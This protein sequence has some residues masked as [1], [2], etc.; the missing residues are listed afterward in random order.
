MEKANKAEVINKENYMEEKKSLTQ[1]K[2]KSFIN[3]DYFAQADFS[4]LKMTLEEMLKAGVHFGHKKSRRHPKMN[5]Y[6]FAT[7]NGISIFD[8]EKTLIKLQSALDFIKEIKRA[9]RQILFV[10]TKKQARYLIKSAAQRCQMPFVNERW[11]GGTFTNFKMIR[12]RVDYLL[13][14]EDKQEKG[15]FEKYTK[16]EQAQKKDELEKLEKRMGGIKKMKEL[17]GAV[18]IV[19][20]KENITAVREAQ[21]MKIPVVALADSNFNPEEVDYPIP[22][23]DD[24]VSSLKLILS[25]V[26]KALEEQKEEKKIKETNK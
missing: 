8:L 22:A 24:A 19:D 11:L 23:N 9:D 6:I 18:F 12:K 25:Y 3:E 5:P 15:D 26:C 7:K 14:E 2:E 4:Q 21:K 1:K 17:P 16:F 20:P 13:Q 10:G